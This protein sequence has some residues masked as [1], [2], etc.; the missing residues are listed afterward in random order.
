MAKDPEK[1]KAAVKFLEYSVQPKWHSAAVKS[2][3]QLPATKSVADMGIYKGDELGEVMQNIVG[4]YPAGNFG[5]SNP[6]YNKIRKELAAQLQAM[7]AGLKTPE[8]ALADLEV[9]LKK[10]VGQ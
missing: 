9:N 2:A 7:F 5:V 8:T 6:N 10:I 4:K 1:Q 3:G